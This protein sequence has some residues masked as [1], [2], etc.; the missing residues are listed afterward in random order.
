MSNRWTPDRLLAFLIVVIS[1]GLYIF[2]LYIGRQADI[3]ALGELTAKMAHAQK[4]RPLTENTK[5]CNICE[6]DTR[7]D[8]LQD[9]MRPFEDPEQQTRARDYVMI[10]AILKHRMAGR[11][12]SWQNQMWTML[13][14]EHMLGGIVFRPVFSN[15]TRP[16]RITCIFIVFLGNITI[17]TLFLGREGFDVNARIAAGIVSAVIMFPIGLLFS[18][19]FR[20]IDSEVTWRMHRRRRVRRVQENVAVKGAIDLIGK[21]KPPAQSRPK[22]G[23][24]LLTDSGRMLICEI[25]GHRVRMHMQTCVTIHHPCREFSITVSSSPLMQCICVNSR[26]PSGTDQARGDL[27]GERSQHRG[28]LFR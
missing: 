6:P 21:P 24:Q 11:Y 23:A 13:K 14:Q 7:I 4:V 3:R 10:K 1:C 22:Y 12:K 25:I 27:R 9:Q 19:A 18:A 5:M 2:S 8:L 26:R 28:S 17:N 20:A 16:R 15:F